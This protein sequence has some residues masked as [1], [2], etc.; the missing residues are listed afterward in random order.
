MQD[1]LT[2]LEA[3]TDADGSGTE[4]S[5][6]Y[7]VNVS[8]DGDHVY[9]SDYDSIRVFSRDIS[10]GSLT[11]VGVHENGATEKP[12]GNGPK[13]A[14]ISH[15]GKNMYFKWLSEQLTEV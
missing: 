14:S 13:S 3:H 11:F 1:S 15:D 8:P 12:H 7:F 5:S 9:A 6:L 4:F 2:F 10:T